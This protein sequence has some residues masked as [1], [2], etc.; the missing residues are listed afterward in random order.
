MKKLSVALCVLLA[1][2]CVSSGDPT[3]RESSPKE[4]AITNLRLGSEYLKRGDRETAREKLTRAI[5]QDPELAPAHAYL[6][7]TYEQ[8]GQLK[9]ADRQ[10]R[11]AIR[12]ARH[13]ANV[14]NMYAVYLCRRDRVADAD[15][16]FMAAVAIPDYRTPETA[17]TNAGVCQLKVPDVGKAESYFRLALERNPRYIDALWQMARLTHEA[18]RDF[19]TRAFLQRLQEVARLSPEALW[20]GYQIEAAMGDDKAAEGYADELMQSYPES[21]EAAELNEIVGRY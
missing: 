16:Y 9:E 10:Y 1:V 18:G 14:Q 20:L 4:A 17:F 13:D 8:L 6:A 19:Q 12:L 2:G 5:E 21:V 3:K 11:I 7:L 15:K